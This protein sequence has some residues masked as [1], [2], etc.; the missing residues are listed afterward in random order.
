MF[1]SEEFRSA[2]FCSIIG[3]L[4]RQREAA[5]P[6]RRL[7]IDAEIWR[8]VEAAA[9]LR[10]PSEAR[11]WFGDLADR[12]IRVNLYRREDSGTTS[13][14]ARILTLTRT[15]DARYVLGVDAV[16]ELIPETI[17]ESRPTRSPR[18][19]VRELATV[20]AFQFGP[21]GCDGSLLGLLPRVAMISRRLADGM[22]V[23]VLA[24]GA[25]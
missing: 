12:R 17:F 14:C 8:Y 13:T 23:E 9:T 6:E 2:K 18:R 1:D 10:L 20:P 19:L 5:P 15:A 4:W 7:E 25:A 24:G 3:R 21:Q 22:A 11:P 16:E